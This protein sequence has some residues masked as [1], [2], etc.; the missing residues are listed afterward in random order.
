MTR[1]MAGSCG[2]D[3]EDFRL[4]HVAILIYTSSRRRSFQTEPNVETRS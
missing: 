4:L 1:W 3:N 2:Q